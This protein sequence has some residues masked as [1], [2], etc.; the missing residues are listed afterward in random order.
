MDGQD[1][2]QRRMHALQQHL[3]AASVNSE[4][5]P[6]VA[7]NGTSAQTRSIWQDIPQVDALASLMIAI[8]FI[9][10]Q[11][12]HPLNSLLI[13]AEAFKKDPSPDKI[14]L[15]VGAY[16]TEEGKPLVLNVVRKAEQKIINSPTENKEYLGIT[17]NPKFN[18]LS[19]KLA[20]GESSSVIREGRNATVQALSGTGSLRKMQYFLHPQ[21]ANS[22]AAAS[23]SYRVPHAWHA[24]VGAEFLAQHYPMHTVLLPNPTWANH[25]KIFPLAG[26]KDVRKYR[27]FKPATKGLD[28]EGM[29]QDL[30]SAPEGAIVV[31]HACAHNP[32][33]V[34][35][36]SE[37]WRGILKAVQQK[38]LLPFFD[39]AYQVWGG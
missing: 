36:T 35:P 31:L 15:G 16:R 37:Q 25:N 19:A 11:C 2:V 39:S 17:G 9:P 32:T 38:R 1:A 6:H 5:A 14:N 10:N 26:I 34:D 18:E 29:I 23:F 4:K 8:G 27:Y 20:F 30:Q 3:T 22:I 24:Q 12:P 33:G 28:Y 13:S 21:I 7:M